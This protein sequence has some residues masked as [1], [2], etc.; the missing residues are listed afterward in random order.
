[1]PELTS[2]KNV[3]WGVVAY[4][5]QKSKLPLWCLKYS[6]SVAT[7]DFRSLIDQLVELIQKDEL[8]D[9]VV[10]KVLWALRQHQFELSRILLNTTAFEEGFKT[11]V[12][13][14]KDV[15]IKYEWWDELKAYLNQQM[16]GEVGFWKE[17]DIETAILRFSIKKNEKDEVKNIAVLPNNASIEKGTTQSFY[18]SVEI[19]GNATKDVTWSVENASASNIDN[20]GVLKIEATE[21][22]TDLTVK[23]TSKFD[24]TKIGIASVTIASSVSEIK[25]QKAK[26]K[27]AKVSNTSSIILKNVLLQILEKFPQV[28]EMIDENLDE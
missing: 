9:D 4:C 18:A 10:K 7:D 5:K 12:Q 25:I 14:I 27:V 2:L 16:Q 26:E 28:A 19:T 13:N 8:K 23:A 24:N 21:T 6:Q 1:V 3:R 20:F 17:S 22:S 11:F 15:T